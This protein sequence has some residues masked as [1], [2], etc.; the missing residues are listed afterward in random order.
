MIPTGMEGRTS[1]G[2]R[3]GMRGIPLGAILVAILVSQGLVIS[4]Y[5]AFGAAA[6]R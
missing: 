5:L 4:A 6:P 2:S 3:A 1:A